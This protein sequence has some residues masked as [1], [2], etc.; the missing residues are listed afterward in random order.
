MAKK[1]K[2]K[3]KRKGSESKNIIDIE[4]RREERRKELRAEAEASRAKRGEK[5][6]MQEMLD[7][8]E[9]GDEYDMAYKPE[10]KT[11]KKKAKKKKP[12][13]ATKLCLAVVI[14][15]GIALIFS[16]GNIVSL[17]VQEIQAEAELAALQEQKAELERQVEEIGSDEYMERQAREWLKM[18]KEGEIIYSDNGDEKSSDEQ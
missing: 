16:I 7:E 12:S 1:Q 4:T 3:K 10:K 17:K 2:K 18:A 5:S 6:I 9:R 8:I 11:E 14:V 15:V 13:F